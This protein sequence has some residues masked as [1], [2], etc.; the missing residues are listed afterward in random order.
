MDRYE[1]LMKYWLFQS[2]GIENDVG[3]GKRVNVNVIDYA[4]EH[5]RRK[6]KF[7]DLLQYD[8]VM[9][10]LEYFTALTCMTIVMYMTVRGGVCIMHNHMHQMH[11]GFHRYAEPN[12]T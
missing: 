3:E 11:A 10:D 12:E 5:W 9:N 2:E 1:K 7:G 8:V 4:G 6:V